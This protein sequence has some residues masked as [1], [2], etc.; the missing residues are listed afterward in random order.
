M[1]SRTNLESWKKLVAH[2]KD[3]KDQ[4]MNDLFAKNP[5]RFNEFSI[6]LTPFILDYSKNIITTETMSLLTLLADR[7]VDYIKSYIESIIVVYL[8]TFPHWFCK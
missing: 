1:K 7:H 8:N 3:M 5:S 6:K 4:H 2:A